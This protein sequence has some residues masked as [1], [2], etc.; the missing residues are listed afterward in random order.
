MDVGSMIFVFL[1]GNIYFAAYFSG[2]YEIS[3][4][5]LVVQLGAGWRACYEPKIIK[6]L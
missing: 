3:A 5:V 1:P 2:E 6:L 4:K